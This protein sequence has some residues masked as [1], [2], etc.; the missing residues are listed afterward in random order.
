[1]GGS[2]PL[3]ASG[4]VPAPTRRPLRLL[5]TVAVSLVIAVGCQVQVATTVRVAGDGTGTVTQAVGFD[6]AALARVGDLSEQLRVDDLRVAGWTVDD[7]AE[8]GELTW[9]RAH[10]DFADPAEANAL[11]AQL[12]GPDGP[13]RGLTVTRDDGL[14]ATTTAV[15][16]TL[17]LSAGTAMFGDPQ[18]T[19]TLG[20]DP[21][22]GLLARIEAEEGRP[23]NEMVQVALTVELP[24]ANRTVDDTLGAAPQPVDASSRDSHV[25]SF[26]EMVAL[27]AIVVFTALVVGLRFRVRR[28]RRKRMMRSNLPRR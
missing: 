18:L 3:V 28:Q 1:M 21:S 17:D 2:C 6:G 5:A 4:A 27:A 15:A 11:L 22:G 26:V 24:D 7:P 16:G 9:V 8:E 23:A 10:H 13:F 14:L 20:G 25:V 12:S 19:E